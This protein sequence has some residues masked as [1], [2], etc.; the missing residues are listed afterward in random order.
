MKYPIIGIIAFAAAV[1]FI[2]CKQEI[3]YEPPVFPKQQQVEVQVLNEQYLFRYANQP[4]LYDSLLIVGDLN[5]EAYICIFNRYSGNLIR[6]FGRRGNGPGELVTP[7]GY[8]VDKE[9]GFLY[10]N[11]YGRKS[12]FKYDLKHWENGI[13]A[14]QGMC[15]HCKQTN[16]FTKLPSHLSYKWSCN[17]D[18]FTCEKAAANNLRFLLF[19][20]NEYFCEFLMLN[21]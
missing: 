12:I 5:D 15:E 14:Y 13:P 4:L 17:Q 3:V 20:K 1:G 10:V 11:D 8:S 9:K 7:V 6:S 16:L 18:R 21:R 19:G 2:S